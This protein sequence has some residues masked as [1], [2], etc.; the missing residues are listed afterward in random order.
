VCVCVCVCLGVTV[1]P[2]QLRGPCPRGD[3][4]CENKT[5]FNEWKKRQFNKHFWESTP[6]WCK[7]PAFNLIK[8]FKGV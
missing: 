4:A 8:S 6:N 2:K 5:I 7:V 1:K 3:V